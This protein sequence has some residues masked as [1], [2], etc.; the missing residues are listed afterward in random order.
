[1]KEKQDSE[2]KH[3]VLVIDDEPAQLKTLSDILET[4]EL[5]PVCCKTGKEALA[6]CKK[7]KVNVAILDLRLPDVDGMDLLKQLK[8]QTPEIKVI[9]NTGYASLESAMAAINEEAFA[10]VRKMGDVEELLTHVHRA[11]HAHLTRYSQQL[12]QQVRKR[13]AELSRTNKKLKKEIGQKKQME[14]ALLRRGQMLEIFSQ[15]SQ[16]INTVL[17]VPV[18]LDKLV[19]SAIKLVEGTSGT[20]GLLLEET[21]TFNR[22]NDNGK[23]ISIRHTFQAGQGVPGLVMKTRKP[24]ISNAAQNDPQ[25]L[26]E[27][28]EALGLYNLANVPI[29]DRKGKLLGCIE[30]HNKRAQRLFDELDVEMLQGLAASAA[31]ALENA[32][33]LGESKR[34]EEALC[35]EKEF[36]EFLINSSVDGIIAFDCECR[37]TVWNHG[38]ERLSGLS[39]IETLGNIAFDIFPFLKETGEDR[40]YF[41]ALAGRSAVSKE[42]PFAIPETGR[43]GFFDGYYSP[44]LNESGVIIG[45]LAIIHDITE[46]KQLQEQLL[47]AQKMETIGTLVGGV[48]HDF[49]NLLTVILGNVEF[50]M[51][52]SEPKDAIYRDLIEIEKA[53]SQA[54]DLIKQLLSFS[55]REVL[56]PRVLNLNHTIQDLFKMLNRIIGEDIALEIK[57]DPKLAPIWAD[58]V[59]IRQVLMNLFVNARDAMSKGG[60]LSLATRNLETGFELPGTGSDIHCE[61]DVKEG[62]RESTDHSNG[63]VEIII[64]DSG[65]GM[66]KETQTRI[67]EPFFTTKERRKGTGLG[68]SVVYGIV[69]QHGGHIEVSSKI[70]CGTTFRLYFPAASQTAALETRKAQLQARSGGGE[71]ILLV[72]DEETVLNVAVR[73]LKLFGYHVLTAEDGKQAMTVFEAE[74]KNIDAAILDVVMPKMSGPDVYKKL[75]S[76]KPDLPVIFATGYDVG[77]EIDDLVGSGQKLVSVLRKPY[78]KEALGKKVEEILEAR[79]KEAASVS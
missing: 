65:L 4:E 63:F 3:P 2:K 27:I 31:V 10:Y 29:I 64:G 24:Y 41:D 14:E 20:A 71:T 49:N 25:V 11:F 15:T 54:R 75:R 68:L 45:G 12:E 5:Q 69:K 47:Q 30:I 16:Q 26:P 22:Y 7:H 35:R 36:S 53:A 8:Q 62:S 34:S 72:E 33:L 77:A 6:A 66:D 48:A 13:T 9:I 56:E 73:M 38:M 67:F 74:S 19:A 46:R 78:S 58:P 17:E 37:Y 43:Q 59:Q 70:G 60:Q 18:I 51:Q 28:R 44:L 39:S 52:D 57:L 55:R 79:G 1:M 32:Q 42:R 50:G 21:M 61:L 76:I 40:F 23:V